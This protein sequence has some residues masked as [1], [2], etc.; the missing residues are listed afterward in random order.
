[1]TKQRE[2][3]Y[4]LLRILCAIAVVS[5]HVTAMYMN[6]SADENVFGEIYQTGLFTTYLYN[7]LSRFAVPCFLMLSGAFVLGDKRN[8]DFKYFYK[9]SFRSIGITA[10]LFGVLYTL[11]ALVMSSHGSISGISDVAKDVISGSPYYHLWYLSTL[12]GLYIIAPIVIRVAG[13]LQA[14]GI[15]LFGKISL[16]FLV[17]ACIGNSTST[18]I[19]YWDI[20]EQFCY[21]GYFLVGYTIRLWA[22]DRKNNFRAAAFVFGGVL[23]ECMLLCVNYLIAY[24][25]V[26][27][28][29]F[30]VKVFDIMPL[31]PFEV[32]AS[33]LIFAGFSLLNINVDFS[34][35]SSYTFL[36]YL[37]HAVVWD[38][39]AFFIRRGLYRIIDNRVLIPGCIV[40]VF[41]ISLLG[42]IVYRII[43][44]FLEDKLS[45]TDRICKILKL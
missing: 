17:L 15:N 6:A 42:S 37:L 14:D 12:L 2:S 9:K 18:H 10:L 3:N 40:L 28:S 34:K 16:V 7:I 21:L 33:V 36:I 32:L 44:S 45:I 19:L 8:A 22:A 25:E 11:L 43:W 30:W 38:F 39:M 35:L 31:A 41:L 1:M 29:E 13:S 24:R 26:S 20:G 27:V 5:I 4:D 23:V